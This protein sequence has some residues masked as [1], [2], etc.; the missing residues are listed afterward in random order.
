MRIAIAGI[1]HWHAPRY[2]AALEAEGCEIVGVSDADPAALEGR[3]WPGFPDTAAMLAATTPHLVL[4]LPRHDRALQEARTVAAFRRPVLAEKPLGLDAAE[5]AEAARLL[6]EGHRFAAACLP[7]RHLLFWDAIAALREEGRL[8]TPVHMGVRIV[9]GPPSRYPAYGVP[10]ML[11]PARSGGG[12]LRNLGAHGCDAARLLGGGAMAVRGA[13]V[14]RRGHGLAIEDYA[15]AILTAPDGF[16]ATIEVGYSHADPA[17]SDQEFRLAATGAYVVD[18]NGTLSVTLA[19]GTRRVTPSRDAG[20]AYA[21]LVRDALDRFRRGAPPAADVEDC[22]AA[23][24]L[25]DAIYDKAKGG[26]TP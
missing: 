14:E 26:T 19:D 5:A 20:A 16:V 8:G 22:A 7:N 25:I 2:V 23:V 10:W 15:T 1:T 12:V 24:A 3:P 18:A 11:D 9:N 13:A 6:R 21:E 4:L 17:A